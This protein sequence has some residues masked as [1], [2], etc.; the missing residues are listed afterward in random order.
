MS[1]RERAVGSVRWAVVYVWG[2]DLV[3]AIG[4]VALSRLLGAPTMGLVAMA[5]LV[6]ELSSI[7]Q[8]GIQTAIVQRQRPEPRQ[9]DTA[10]W[11]CALTGVLTAA[12][13]MLSAGPVARVLTVPE[14]EPVLRP[15][16]LA[17]VPLG[18]ATVPVARLQRDFG[19]RALA[20][21][22]FTSVSLGAAVGIA[23]GLLQL[24]I[25]SAVAMHLTTAC[26][27]CALLWVGCD[28]RPKGGASW[29]EA[30][31][32]GAFGAPVAGRDAVGFLQRRADELLVGTFLGPGA[33]GYYAVG[34]RFT[35]LVS[36]LFVRSVASVALP[37]FARLQHDRDRL[38][39]ALTTTTEA[40]G[41]FALPALLGMATL[42]SEI[43]LAVFGPGWERSGPVLRVWSLVGVVVSL[44]HLHRHA[45]IAAGRPGW[46]LALAS[47]QALAAIGGTA[48][49]LALGAGLQG[50]A[51]VAVG[52]ALVVEPL[53][54]VLV[55]RV[56]GIV[57]SA[58][59]LRFAAPLAAALI[60]AA[61]V[62]SVRGLLPDAWAPIPSLSLLVLLGMLVHA[63]ALR[64]LG[65]RLFERTLAHARSLFI[66]E[67]GPARAG[68]E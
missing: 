66:R 15:L 31:R 36:G 21:Q 4:F 7:L 11:M 63:T 19:F 64:L 43:V 50:V 1:L 32:L 26:A 13:W 16:A 35:A 8:Q 45:L 24:G 38:R 56:T 42:S 23:M 53:A 9:L 51:L 49:A 68:R 48:A 2:A 25:H 40:I 41:V 60:M 27:S 57:L 17:L 65:P 46:T 54:L 10:F 34:T 12:C 30:R 18:L 14:L 29:A 22:R 47:L 44:G 3:G 5:W 61:C 20:I 58:Y 6:V 59:L 39:A 67:A 37:T 52:T 55:R 62:H 33:L 28:W